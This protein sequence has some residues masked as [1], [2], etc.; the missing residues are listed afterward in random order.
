MPVAGNKMPSSGVIAFMRRRPPGAKLSDEQYER[1]KAGD[2]YVNVHS[3]ARPGGGIR[4][5]IRR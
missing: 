5:Q 1:Y 3:K 4:A 2:L